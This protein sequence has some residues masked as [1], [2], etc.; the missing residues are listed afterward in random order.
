MYLISHSTVLCTTYL[1]SY[2]TI[3]STQDLV[4][5]NKKPVFLLRSSVVPSYTWGEL[6]HTNSVQICWQSTAARSTFY[7]K[8]KKTLMNIVRPWCHIYIDSYVRPPEELL[9]LKGCTA[10]QFALRQ[11]SIW[12][13]VLITVSRSAVL[14]LRDQCFTLFPWARLFLL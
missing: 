6:S 13:E 2:L 11:K 14:P 4:H 10:I 5:W 7:L 3:R 8:F 12:G 9:W 1:Y